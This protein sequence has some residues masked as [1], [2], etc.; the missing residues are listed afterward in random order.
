MSLF[1]KLNA[2]TFFC[3]WQLTSSFAQT[4]AVLYILLIY[5][6]SSLMIIASEAGVSKK[7]QLGLPWHTGE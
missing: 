7:T 3:Q 2:D 4:S 5:A 1:H 6:I